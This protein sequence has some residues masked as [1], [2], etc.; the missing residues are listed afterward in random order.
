MIRL[1]TGMPGHGK[2]LWVVTELARLADEHASRPV[3]VRG[4]G[5]LKVDHVDL[6][7][8][9]D[10][11][12]CPDGALIVI[13]EA[14]SAFPT[15]GASTPPQWVS[16]LAVHRHRGIDLWLITQHPGNIDSFVRERLIEEHI[17][18][19]R[20]M[21]TQ[22]SMVYKWHEVQT[23]PRSQASKAAAIVT[24][25]PFPKASF[26]LYS[27]AV[28]HTGKSRLP[29]G[30]LGLIAACIVAVPLLAIGAFSLLPGATPV[31]PPSVLPSPQAAAALPVSSAMSADQWL[32]RYEPRVPY[33]PES[34]PAYDRLIES[35][36]PPKLWCM[37]VEVRGCVCYTDQMTLWQG[38]APATC[39][40]IA[41][42]GI[43]HVVANK[44]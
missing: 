6:A 31:E 21:G 25:F 15:R 14:Q 12:K 40:R 43:Y 26:D 20:V 32:A 18:V 2:T 11:N 19:M 9:R 23:D 5:G 29:F 22:S 27:S 37:D 44:N 24:P 33:R 13:D 16:D 38:V 35:A 42:N 10:W 34:A 4:I 28:M 30:K 3:Y 7:D 8:G 39:K 17:H 1:I 41:R 36:P